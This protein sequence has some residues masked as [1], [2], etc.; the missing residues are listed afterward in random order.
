MTGNVLATC[1]RAPLSMGGL[2]SGQAALR[3]AQD[4][5]RDAAQV[6]VLAGVRFWILEIKLTSDSVSPTA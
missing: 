2:P 6:D 5:L 4:K 1:E 3:Q